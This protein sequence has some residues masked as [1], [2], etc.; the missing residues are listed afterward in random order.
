MAKFCIFF[1]QND[2]LD[3]TV[4]TQKSVWKTIHPDLRYIQNR[5]LTL[6]AKPNRQPKT[7]FNQYLGQY[8]VLLQTDFCIETVRSCRS[9]WVPWKLYSEREKNY[10]IWSFASKMDFKKPF[11]GKIWANGAKRVFIWES[12]SPKEV[13]LVE[14]SHAPAN[15]FHFVM[16]C[17][18]SSVR[19]SNMFMV[20]SSWRLKSP[21]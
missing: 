6:W 7:D 18:L 4:P 20:S 10:K 13:E 3:P 8:W 1:P 2:R 15:F 5:F 9:F 17:N 11:C 16:Q 21:L 14:I 12:V 19:V